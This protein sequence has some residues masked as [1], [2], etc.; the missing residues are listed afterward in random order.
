MPLP[1]GE[2]QTGTG[3][4]PDVGAQRRALPSQH[5]TAARDCPNLPEPC[6]VQGKAN[7]PRR[8]S[9]A[10]RAVTAEAA[11]HGSGFSL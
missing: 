9:A 1:M 5:H 6:R 11:G 4:G 7:A 10:R 3:C 2:G 8:A